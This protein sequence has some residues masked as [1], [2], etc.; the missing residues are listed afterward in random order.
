MD[1]VCDQAYLGELVQTLVMAGQLV[2]AA[3]ASSLSDRFGRKTVLLTSH[4]LTLVFGFG[5]AFSPN[6]MVL[7]ILKFI[8]GVLQQVLH[9]E[10]RLMSVASNAMFLL[11]LWTNLY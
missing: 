3:F 2:G 11:F 1:L 10:C 7:A 9:T 6:Y 4:L 8:L 5:V